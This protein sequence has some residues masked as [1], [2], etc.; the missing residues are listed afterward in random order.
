MC[1][2]T[3]IMKHVDYIMMNT[4]MKEHLSSPPPPESGV[5]FYQQNHVNKTLTLPFYR[6]NHA[7]NR[8]G[9][10]FP[11]PAPVGSSVHGTVYATRPRAKD[12]VQLPS[13]ETLRQNYTLKVDKKFLRKE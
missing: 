1:T 2:P 7:G 4:I 3:D 5:L 9:K 13:H 12:D 10:C 11:G 6:K 8:P